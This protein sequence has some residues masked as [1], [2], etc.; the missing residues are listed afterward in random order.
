MTS[1][2]QGGINFHSACKQGAPVGILGTLKLA[3]ITRKRS[4][5][6]A[7]NRYF[8]QNE[9]SADRYNARGDVK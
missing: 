2:K 8:I 5:T 4:I 3:E 6:F 7:F 1:D 9:I